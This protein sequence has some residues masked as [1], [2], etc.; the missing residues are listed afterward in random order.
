MDAFAVQHNAAVV[1]L[2]QEKVFHDSG[3]AENKG[4]L[5]VCT[6][7]ASHKPQHFCEGEEREE[8]VVVVV[9]ATFYY[10]EK[11]QLRWGHPDIFTKATYVFRPAAVVN[12]IFL[13]KEKTSVAFVDIPG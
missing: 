2:G 10:P 5:C 7:N 4:G 8:E 11:P 9:I 3:G 13:N 12:N 1:F 6:A